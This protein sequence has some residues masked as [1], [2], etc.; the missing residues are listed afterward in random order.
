MSTLLVEVRQAI[1]NKFDLKINLL[2]KILDLT[3]GHL[4]KSIS[5]HR[6]KK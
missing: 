6:Q 2:I 5:N 4:T 1:L 3:Q